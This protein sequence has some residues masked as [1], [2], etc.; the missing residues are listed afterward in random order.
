MNLT[1]EQTEVFKSSLISALVS[2]LARSAGV[3]VEGQFWG[4]ET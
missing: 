3:S 4:H 2:P 1:A